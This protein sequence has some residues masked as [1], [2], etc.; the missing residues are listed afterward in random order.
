MQSPHP[1]PA[2][3]TPGQRRLITLS[4][5]LAT[6]MQAL[7]TTIANVALP[8]I[9]GSL[10][11]AA[12]QITWV[13][14]SYIVA[15]AIATPLT[16]WLAGRYGRKK[17]FLISVAGFTVASALCGMAGSLGQ[18]VLFR[19]LQGLCGA[20]LVPLSQAVLLDINPPEK[21]GSAMAVWGA[22]IMVGPILGP[23]LGGW[24]T[25]N[26][27][28]RWVFYIN[29]PV[30]I[31][32]FLGIAAFIHEH[33]RDDALP[34]DFFGFGTLS[35]GV[36]ALQM[37][38]DRG[39]LK[40][41]FG[42]NEIWIEAILSLLG[43]YLFIVHTATSR[44]ITFL[45]RTLLKDRN[46][47]TGV[48]FI[49]F[50]GI[51]LYATLALLPPMLQGLFAYPVTTTGLVTAPRGLGTMIAMILVG[52]MLGKV[53][54]RLILF[55]G[56]SMT[57]FSLWQMTRFDLSMGMAP[58]IISG[59]SQGFGLGFVFVPLSTVSFATIAHHLRTDGTAIFSLM[60][61]I[62]SSIG[63]SIVEA[64]LTEN[65]Q[66]SHANLVEHLRPDNPL[67]WPLHLLSAT[68][69][70][71]AALNAEITRQ[72]AMVAYLD[73]FHLMMVIVLVVMPMLLLMKNGKRPVAAETVPLD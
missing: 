73:D 1:A 3:L 14:T 52:R 43:F 55:G 61:N 33:R 53:N 39:E 13:L 25:D 50:V 60:R 67:A 37:L 63:I 64:L 20:A 38:L 19:L 47:V 30:G 10:S 18:I 70:Q 54:I 44:H 8:H 26:Y 17:V 22:G 29:L 45:N 72:A 34:F 35:L 58:V 6:V 69:G 12:D 40:G 66:V 36:G 68:T 42:S 27:N 65:T 51:I 15:A 48:I 21:H 4:I 11:A 62:G 41:W 5:M 71:W 46:F 28:W 57:A 16:G 49:F 7:D 2:D 56:L 24:L 59:L 23:A 9:Q 32:A 31:L